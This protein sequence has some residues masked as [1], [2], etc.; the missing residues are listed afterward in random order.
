MSRSHSNELVWRRG[1]NIFE[2]FIPDFVVDYLK[3]FDY[4]IFYKFHGVSLSTLLCLAPFTKGI[5]I[6]EEEFDSLARIAIH[7]IL[8]NSKNRLHKMCT[9]ALCGI[10]VDIEFFVL[11]FLSKPSINAP[12]EVI[13]FLENFSKQARVSE[14]FRYYFRSP[15]FHELEVNNNDQYARILQMYD[16]SKLETDN[17]IKRCLDY[18]KI[19]QQDNKS[20]D[21][22]LKDGSKDDK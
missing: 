21:P 9:N 12:K 6:T 17:P 19:I 7:L 2:V 11:P 3:T 22:Q 20:G 10:S 5:D 4:P 8:A 14:N 18:L 16:Y 1:I 15:Y 13:K